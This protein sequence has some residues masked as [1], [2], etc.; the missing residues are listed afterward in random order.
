MYKWVNAK[1]G[2]KY[3]PEGAKAFV[4][5]ANMVISALRYID[6]NGHLNP[7]ASTH[8]RR[9]IKEIYGPI[10]YRSLCVLPKLRLVSQSNGRTKG[11]VDVLSTGSSSR[12]GEKRKFSR[13]R[14]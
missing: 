7:K 10:G 9:V 8:V 4:M 2:V 3:N 6:V 5:C 13:R 12:S 14:G 1:S 11:S